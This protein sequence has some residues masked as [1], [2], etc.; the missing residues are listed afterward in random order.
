MASINAA[1]T[2]FLSAVEP[3]AGIPDPGPWLEGLNRVNKCAKTLGACAQGAQPGELAGV[4]GDL[5]AALS[6]PDPQVG[7]E[8][9]ITLGVFIEYG[10]PPG[11]V[12]A[13]LL[14][15]FQRTLELLKVF[16]KRVRQEVPETAEDAESEEEAG[17]YWIE[18]RFVSPAL[19][20]KFWLQ[21][22]RL[23]QAHA[24]LDNWCLPVVAALS[25]DR[26][27]LQQAQ[28]NKPLLDVVTE[29]DIGFVRMLLRLLVRETLLVLHPN[30]GKGFSVLIDGVADNFQLHTL[31]ADALLTEKGFLRKK[32]PPWGI[33]GK[34]P[35][36]R[37]VATMRGEGPQ[38]I[39]EPSTGFWNLYN[40]A[41]LGR[42]GRLPT[43][44]DTEH[45]IWNEGM[46][47]DI[48]PFEG[49]RV[50]LLGPPL[51]E[52]SWN[53]ARAIP[54]LKPTLEVQK[55]LEEQDVRQWLNRLAAA[56]K[57]PTSGTG[58]TQP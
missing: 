46:P 27:L 44:T 10:L 1:S 52:R 17:G 15:G 14:Q 25:R 31:L 20:Q 45:W 56:P 5:T 9:A 18:D 7:G 6:A 19:A 4:A 24:A 30:T 36:S 58:G 43:G 40:W 8:A 28:M 41:A 11:I 22:R 33:P 48:L 32:G 50:V 21:D 54:A 26:D 13:A 12:G 37:V 47:A 2:E 53:T 3:M 34:R 49:Q 39:A 42:D 16:T 38:S 29:L 23:P 35:S 55:V 51:Y 57:P